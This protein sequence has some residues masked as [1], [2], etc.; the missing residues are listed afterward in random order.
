MTRS[1]RY[2]RETIADPIAREYYLMR[3]REWMRREYHANPEYRR[4]KRDD[5]ARRYREYVARRKATNPPDPALLRAA[6]LNAGL[7]LAQAAAVLGIKHQGVMALE[8]R[9]RIAPIPDETLQRL[10]AAYNC[11]VAAFY[12]KG[13]EL[14]DERANAR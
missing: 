2:Y 1:S 5:T 13:D 7:S 3:Q 10:A 9:N 14:P 12:R 6:R 8:H 4:R 11:D